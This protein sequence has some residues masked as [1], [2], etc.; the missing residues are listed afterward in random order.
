MVK[1]SKYGSRVQKNHLKNGDISYYIVYKDG[2]KTIFQKV[3]RK[4]EGI[5]EKKA[6]DLRSQKLSELRHGQDLSQKGH[7]HL[8]FDTLASLYFSSN[9]AHNKSNH[10]NKLMYKKHIKYSFGD[11]TISRLDDTLISELQALKKASGLSSSTNNQ[12]VKLIKR[13]IGFGQRQGILQYSPFKNIKLFRVNNTRLRFLSS[14]EIKMLH[15]LVEDDIVLN[16][17][18]KIA[19]S[20]G[21]RV[22]SILNLQKKHINFE[23]KSITIK[24]FKRGNYYT[25]YLDAVTFEMLEKHLNSFSI[26]EHVVSLGGTAMKY[27]KL[28]KQLS[29]VFDVFNDGL[30]REDRANRV[31]IHTLRH[32][33]ASH[34][35]IAGVSIQEIQ[36]LMNHK[37]IKQTEKY[38]KLSPGS[39]RGYVESLYK[40]VS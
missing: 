5:T 40:E 37:D 35:A 38:A 21:A 17:F 4:S 20:T 1:S 8:T 30:S 26:N 9:E 33:F 12:I 34:L 36:K 16:L 18:V 13:I 6:M 14:S 2:T 10:S 19:L 25:G 15:D 27:Q 39:G 29:S 11:I 28:Y 7:K 22:K 3:G 24:D 23:T 32:T 31:V